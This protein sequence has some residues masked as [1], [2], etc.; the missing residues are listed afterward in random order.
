VKDT[1]RVVYFIS[2]KVNKAFKIGITSNLQQRLS[3]LQTGNANKLTVDSVIEDATVALERK[4]QAQFK[5]D[6]ISGE[7]F[8]S[9]VDGDE[10]LVQHKGGIACLVFDT[11]DGK[12]V[13]RKKFNIKT[14]ERFCIV[15]LDADG[16]II[17]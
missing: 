5:A 6:R 10:L 4:L 3:E 11:E 7:W 13:F 2:D 12:A 9:Y 15:A 16:H 8:R 1:R 17:P 14:G